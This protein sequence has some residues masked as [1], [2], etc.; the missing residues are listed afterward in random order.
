MKAN[1]SFTRI[2]ITYILALATLF[3][4]ALFIGFSSPKDV[5]AATTAKAEPLAAAEEVHSHSWSHS[6]EILSSSGGTISG[7]L[8]LSQ[9]V[10][11]S[12]NITVASG[13]TLNI[14]LNGHTL[15][16]SVSGAIFKINGG[17]LNLYDCKGGGVVTGGNEYN[18]GGGVSLQSGVFNMYGGTI[19][20]NKSSWR[21]AGVYISAGEFNLNAGTISGN[22]GSKYG[23]N[24]CIDG[25]VFNMSG[26]TISGSS[27]TYGGGVSVGNG[28]FNLT[29]G[30]ISGNTATY[31]GGVSYDHNGVF[32]M[33]GGKIAD[34]K[35]A[36]YGGGVYMMS[37]SNNPF[38][39]DTGEISGNSAISGGG[40]YVGSST[41][42]INDGTITKNT[43]YD[44]GGVY[45]SKSGVKFD[46]NNGTISDNSAISGGGVYFYGA[47]SA[48]NMNG[49]ATISGNSAS[50]KGGGVFVAN[51]SV[52]NL[53]SGNI[54]NNK[55]TGTS[56]PNDGGG[57]YVYNNS[58]FNMS[59]GSVSG[60]TV[61]GYG[62]GVYVYNNSTFNMSG[63]SVSENSA[64]GR[65]G[66]GGGVLVESGTLFNMS[67][68]SVTSNNSIMGGG[69]FTYGAFVMTGGSVSGNTASGNNG[70]GVY[71]SGTINVG[72]HVNIAGN[73]V[74]N[75]DNNVYLLA[76]KVIT[77]DSML[78][79]Q[80][81]IGV[82]PKNMSG[83]FTKGL[84]GKGTTKNFISDAGRNVKL[85]GDGEAVFGDPTVTTT[86]NGISTLYDSISDAW[87][88]AKTAGKAIIE[89][90]ADQEATNGTLAVASGNDI[91]LNL[92][93]Y[94]LR[95]G[96]GTTSGSVISVSGGNFTLID[97]YTGS[98]TKHIITNPA[99][100]AQEEITGGV[101]TGGTGTKG[102]N[103][104]GGGL[105]IAGGVF[106]M[107]G[108]T[109]AGNAA[110]SQGGGIRVGG[111]GEFIMQDGTIC[112][113]TANSGGGVRL[114]SGSFTMDGGT[115]RDNQAS[116]SGGGVYINSGYTF[117]MNGGSILD[118]TVTGYG[119]GVDVHGTLEM[120]GGTIT[121]NTA[122]NGGGVHV[123]S[124][125]TMSIS[126]DINITGNKCDDAA[127]DVYLESGNILDV[128]GE[129]KS[130]TRIGITLSSGDGVFT[131]GLS[132]NGTVDN[133]IS[134]K[135]GY[136]SVISDKDG[137]AGEAMLSYGIAIV[138]T[139]HYASV[140][141]LL[142]AINEADSAEV[143][144]L[145]TVVLD[146]VALVVKSGQTVTLNLNGQIVTGNGK[147]S[148]VK[149]ENGGIL[150]LYDGNPT[151]TNTVTIF[152]TPIEIPGGVITGGSAERGGG[153]YIGENG[154]F[155]MFGGTIV[156]NSAS[157][158]GGVYVAGGED[159]E[160]GVFNM[161]G[162]TIVRNRS[163]AG[164]GVY[165]HSKST[166]IM[167]GGTI[168]R[169]TAESNGGGVYLYSEVTFNLFNGTVSENTAESNGGGIYVYSNSEV[170]MSGG[171]I[172]DNEA[173]DGA[174][175]HVYGTFD[176]SG[177]TIVGNMAS[178]NGAGVYVGGNLMVSG[179]L[180][181]TGNTFYDSS[182][183]NVYL[184]FGKF[185]SVKGALTNLRSIGV[186]LAGSTGTITTGLS[187]GGSL[188]NFISDN[189][190][191]SIVLN[192]GEAY[193]GGAIVRVIIAGTT[194]D[195]PT[196][197]EMIY[198][199]SRRTTGAT[200]KLLADIQVSNDLLVISSEEEIRVDLNGH[201]LIGIGTGSVLSIKG[202]G[203]G[204]FYIY[205]SSEEKSGLITGGNAN[206]GGAIYMNSG[207]VYLESGAISGNVATY[208]GGVYVAGGK[209]V[210]TG[211]TISDNS[212]TYGGGVYVAGGEF[213]MDVAKTVDGVADLNSDVNAGGQ[214]SVLGCQISHNT[215]SYGG[216]VYVA[217]GIFNM[218]HGTVEAGATDDA[219]V[220][221]VDANTT[222]QVNTADCLISD[223][224]AAYGGGVFVVGGA[225]YMKDSEISGNMAVGNGG[226][227]YIT[228][229]IFNVCG[230]VNIT[231]NTY[232]DGMS[233]N[234]VFL[235]R[236]NKFSIIDVLSDEA[237]IG[238]SF[239]Y[240]YGENVFTVG[241][242][243]FGSED[244]AKVNIVID[245]DSEN[246]MIIDKS[247]EAVLVYLLY[248]K[249]RVNV[250]LAGLRELI[251]GGLESFKDGTLD[252]IQL[253]E[254]INKAQGLVYE[255]EKVNGS[256]D[257]LADVGVIAEANALLTAYVTYYENYL[258]CMN[259]ANVALAE[260]KALILGGFD[261]LLD[262][263]VARDDLYAA[264]KKAENAIKKFEAERGRVDS[265]P[266]ASAFDDA[267]DLLRQYD[268]YFSSYEGRS[269]EANSTIEK[270]K[271]LIEGGL[272][273]L[274]E[275]HADRAQLQE[276]I[277]R[278]KI[279]IAYF[280]A[281]EGNIADLNGAYIDGV[282]I[283]DYAN[284]L[285]QQYAAYAATLDSLKGQANTALAELSNLIAGGY[286]DL[287]AG[288]MDGEQLHQAI[289]KTKKAIADYISAG[290]ESVDLTDTGVIDRAQMMLED[291]DKY[292]AVLE[293]FK[294]FL[295]KTSPQIDDTDKA[296]ASAL[297]KK[298]ESM[299]DSVKNNIPS[300]ILQQIQRAKNTYKITLNQNNRESSVMAVN[301]DKV[302][303][304]QLNAPEGYKFVGWFTEDGQLFDDTTWTLDGNIAL[305]ARFEKV[306][307][308]G[309][310]T[311]SSVENSSMVGWILLVV[312]IVIS[313]VGALVFVVFAIKNLVTKSL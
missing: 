116:A 292:L 9:N 201:A 8:Y 114:E 161:Q 218:N 131:V 217:G 37:T 296:V 259:N 179:A 117:A 236:G 177:G 3:A 205:D 82:T 146:D 166:F 106:T 176:I 270:L 54:D 313:A 57:V 298:L 299:P 12:N 234:N 221:G 207:T 159:Y 165:L 47:D 87:E 239:A 164:G 237:R 204:R 107:Q 200:I 173:I 43:A 257:D 85:N 100:G 238:V 86:V 178:R 124:A 51:K 92:N 21:G 264:I 99:N 158:G 289:D 13:T 139:E 75:V 136:L 91:T 24:V 229:G 22:T 155:N 306:A 1:K 125:A 83:P 58:T 112:Y 143:T 254:A 246:G 15:T 50:A 244:T 170:I 241:L 147:D 252:K 271:V 28:T 46:F 220:D 42:T 249:E 34:N 25:G 74:S 195:C 103:V 311:Q 293:E 301:G 97:S 188:N 197:S 230:E 113:N 180:N 288:T 235:V 160:T 5:V 52:L 40:V 81:Q 59:G 174:G 226:G 162:G 32:N 185:I 216:G 294:D 68:G 93:G 90:L 212:A 79:S 258:N 245:N 129:I 62:G 71:V 215:A 48:F 168:A 33:S 187:N 272:E 278:A 4:V 302:V 108:G 55:V 290:G 253:Q 247:G 196:I 279:A 109:I 101:I 6:T 115:I 127:N 231:S 190:N 98:R 10:K 268:E 202:A 30:T 262:K 66:Y 95:G 222:E 210:L 184:P 152:G 35:A 130:S 39:I 242:S 251:S 163:T 76:G 232:S 49:G 154:I 118:N 150:D 266:D 17:T 224:T 142:S 53:K 111:T 70:G 19:S 214:G 304:P 309:G 138:N 213:Q 44:G 141:G 199:V 96:D 175:V 308:I 256:A 80:T 140:D 228:G 209:F 219:S 14:C 265:L 305:Y 63:G 23:G 223:N 240:D 284:N 276:A 78:S 110:E 281:A 61:P 38:T 206:F 192:G 45:I 144:L 134:N 151:V 27:A 60:N 208:G 286:F 194:H 267:N 72:G 297:Q 135:S 65:N 56:S 182:A 287:I 148:V 132:G 300:S 18:G 128:K 193:I 283:I 243:D 77:V 291:Y 119:G 64:T 255:Y 280:E 307:A 104:L 157:S 2:I 120:S 189:S 16:G 67:G 153:V 121:G 203:D 227:V 122:T 181:I 36:N 191:Y 225:F 172:S 145:D 29:G 233:A 312:L 263:T 149:I 137:S 102:T 7:N 31:G 250:I 295:E 198:W 260:L 282:F 169:N 11:I 26:G 183:N 211:G 41:F 133:F 269:G 277:D 94:M 248:S 275:R 105:Y 126:G 88:Y 171:I 156:G 73:K 274:K 89:L 69:V 303:L 186:T 261:S 123:V 285:L 20:G 84:S 273:G 310:L 167:N